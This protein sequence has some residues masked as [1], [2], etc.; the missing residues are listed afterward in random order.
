MNGTSDL[1]DKTLRAVK[2]EMDD[3]NP[4]YF[5]RDHGGNGHRAGKTVEESVFVDNKT[6]VD[7]LER[8]TPVHGSLNSLNVH[9][10]SKKTP[11]MEDQASINST[12]GRTASVEDR[13]TES[14]K[15]QT[16]QTDEDNYYENVTT[17]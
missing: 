11:T 14:E 5:S 16:P 17:N 3:S 9:E 1:R 4:L 12:Q 7:M 15:L 10:N 8:H 13:G 2:I 6:L